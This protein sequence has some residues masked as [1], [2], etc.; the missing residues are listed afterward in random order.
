MSTVIPL[1][2]VNALCCW[3]LTSSRKQEGRSNLTLDEAELS[4]SRRN[5]QKVAHPHM[6]HFSFLLIKSCNWT[7]GCHLPSLITQHSSWG[8]RQS[9]RKAVVRL[10][11]G[12]MM[13][14]NEI[15]WTAAAD[16][17]ALFPIAVGFE[18]SPCKSAC[19]QSRG[20]S[21]DH[22]GMS[23]EIE[24]NRWDIYTIWMP[25]HPEKM[26]PAWFLW[27]TKNL[28]CLYNWNWNV[29]LIVK[30]WSHNTET[31]HPGSQLAEGFQ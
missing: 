10:A 9:G 18:F 19:G 4:S 21:K 11:R 5:M 27:E 3:D 16:A 23:G 1:P 6:T 30:L 8:T 7:R 13:W 20:W 26:A 17:P 28:Q 25:F 29:Q 15:W 31:G 24:T 12:V 2:V 22:Q 14:L